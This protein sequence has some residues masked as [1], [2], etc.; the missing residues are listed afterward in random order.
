MTGRKKKG[1]L[2]NL[3]AAT[4]LIDSYIETSEQLTQRQLAKMEH[5]I[6][7]A[8][9]ADTRRQ[10]KRVY[11]FQE[12][13]GGST[14]CYQVRIA[15]HAYGE[16]LDPL[17]PRLEP[18]YPE[19]MSLSTAMS[20][21]RRAKQLHAAYPKEHQ[22]FPSALTAALDEYNALPMS[23]VLEDGTVVRKKAPSAAPS[24]KAATRKAKASKRENGEKT[25]KQFY[26]EM[27]GLVSHY[28]AERL[29]GADD[30]LAE[31]IYGDFEVELKVIISMLQQRLKTAKTQLDDERQL[32][33][34]TRQSHVRDDFAEL[35]MDPPKPLLRPNLKKIRGQYRALARAYHPDKQPPGA[36]DLS[37]KFHAATEAYNRIVAYYRDQGV[38]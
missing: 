21:A 2:D 29:E 35:G 14:R 18:G 16:Y 36:P 9:P 4:A 37:A 7:D 3:G 38:T 15:L 28:I 11:F 5:R 31:Q 24:R 25:P 20:I 10:W 34:R 12:I 33:D 26:R 23:T 19:R 32:S 1:P 17:W 13:F 27:R 22:L 30:D 8:L 6:W